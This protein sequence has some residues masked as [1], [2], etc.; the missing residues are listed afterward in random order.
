MQM[1]DAADLRVK[2]SS[3]GV[4]AVVAV[5]QFATVETPNLDI[6]FGRAGDVELLQRIET[7]RLHVRLVGLTGG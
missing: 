3:A 2:Q 4:F 6:A 1:V 7:Q 5:D